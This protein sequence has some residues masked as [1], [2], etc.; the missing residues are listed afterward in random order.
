MKSKAFTLI[1]IIVIIVVV[2]ILTASGYIFHNYNTSLED[3]NHPNSSNSLTNSSSEKYYIP[4][5]QLKTKETISEYLYHNIQF[6]IPNPP[7]RRV[8]SI[9]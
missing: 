3:I 8:E 7:Q 6:I 2:G 1:E 9:I 5:D 4:L